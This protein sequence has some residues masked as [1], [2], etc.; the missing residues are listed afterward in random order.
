L[1]EGPINFEANFRSDFSA[2]TSFG[3]PPMKSVTVSS[4]TMAAAP[5]K[6]L[7]LLEGA[8]AFASGIFFYKTNFL[9]SITRHVN[10]AF[11]QNKNNAY[12]LH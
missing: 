5:N 6:N 7:P 8:E 12:L 4:K 1:I 3:D 2:D 9:I 10:S 11:F